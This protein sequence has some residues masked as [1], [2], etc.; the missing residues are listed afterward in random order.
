VWPYCFNIPTSLHKKMARSAFPLWQIEKGAGEEGRGGVLIGETA[1]GTQSPT[2]LAVLCR[3]S[4]CMV[5]YSFYTV[6]L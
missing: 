3:V 1:C 6:T 4:V 5:Y 2:L